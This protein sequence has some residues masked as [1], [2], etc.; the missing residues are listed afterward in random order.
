MAG[1][2]ALETPMM[3]QYLEVR[4][5]Q[6][7]CLLLMRMG[8]FYEA[9]LEDAVELAR[10]TGVALTSRNKDAEQPIS[11]AGVPHHSLPGYLPKLLAAGKRVAIMD[12]LEDPKE[13][14]GLVKRG[15]TRVITPGTLID[16]SGLEAASA[17]WL[18]ALTALEGV[19]GVAALDVSTGRFTVE[20]AAAGRLG[21]ILARLQ[22]AELLLPAELAHDPATPERLARLTAPGAVPPLAGLAAF[23][24]KG[25]DARRFLSERLKVASLEGFGIAGGEDHLAAAAAAALRYAEASTSP[26]A[27]T[28]RTATLAHIRAIVRLHQAEHLII[29]ASCRRNLDLL[30]NSRDGTRAGTLLAAVDRTATAPGARLLAEWLSRPLAEVAGISARH[31]AVAALVAD[32]SLRADLREALTAVYDLERLLARVATGRCNARD[33]VHLAQ[34]LSAAASVRRA[35]QAGS[36]AGLPALLARAADELEPDPALAAAISSTLVDDPPLAIGDGGMVRAGVDADLDAL[37][38]I[39]DDASAW[40]AAY[41]A[42]EAAACGLPRLKVGYN[43]VFGYYIEISKA[44]GDKVPAHFIRKQTLVGAERYITPELKD[45]EDRALGAEDRIRAAELTIFSGLRARCE[46]AVTG[47]QRCAD[48]LSLV[49]VAA[50]LAEVAR[51]RGWCRP[52]VDDSLALELADCR[53]PV[54]EE[55]I[56]RGRFV[57]NDTRLDA[58]TPTTGGVDAAPTPRLAVI[59]GPNMAGKSTYIRQVALAVVLAQAG[60]FVPAR[61]ARLGLVDRVFTRVGAGDELARNLSTFMVEMAETA[62]I[63]NHASRRSLVI[64]D[65]VGRGTSTFDGVSLA[66]AITEYLHDR[67]GCRCLFATHYHELVDLAVDRPGVCNLTVSVAEQDDDVVFLH[68]IVPGAAT[69]S[70]GIHV[71]RLAGVP[72]PVIS[73]AREV[74]ATLEQLNLSLTERERPEARAATAGAPAPV[75]LTLFSTVVSPTVDRLKNLA[76]DELSARQALDLLYSLQAAARQE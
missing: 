74:L 44:N 31:D 60:S 58:G 11:M 62:A 9:F 20:E 10:I 24:W 68:R 30:R 32:D 42:R 65:E 56:G 29:D 51:T 48:A 66:W 17:N 75:Q 49:D 72:A 38:A 70:Y 16:E 73:R 18:V 23:A 71:A 55:V 61:A 43:K 76:L 52:Q 8:D 59:T 40:L 45:Y 12:Q 37:R 13:A 15:L 50:A 64:L 63:L 36:P 67:L 19:V 47:L 1:S 2:P 41:Q 21:I 26:A 53:H 34:S 4:A 28:S 22:P 5:S 35:L 69:K 27:G 57:A 7:G 54:V 3:R 25:G 39:K 6:P 14:K 46:A 33:L